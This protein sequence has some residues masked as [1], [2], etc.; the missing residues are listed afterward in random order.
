MDQH[1]PEPEAP[2]TL[3]RYSIE[4]PLGEGAGGTT[5]L[6]REVFAGPACLA[7]AS[8]DT[9]VIKVARVAAEAE[10][11][12]E[13]QALRRFK[14]R[15]IPKLLGWGRSAEGRTYMAL[16]ALPGPTLAA[17]MR[18][19]LTATETLARARSL[20]SAVAALHAAQIIHGD[21]KPENLICVGETEVALVDFGCVAR[22]EG[23]LGRGSPRY[24]APEILRGAPLSFATDRFSVGVIVEALIASAPEGDIGARTLECTRRALTSLTSVDP[25]QRAP[26]LSALLDALGDSQQ[27]ASDR[28]ETL[29]L[30]EPL[31]EREQQLEAIATS[32]DDWRSQGGQRG[33]WIR[34]VAGSGRSALL[35]E[36]LLLASAH[37]EVLKVPC[38]NFPDAA[39]LP[40]LEALRTRVANWS[41]PLVLGIDDWEL[42]SLSAR[43]R[44]FDRID[45]HP[46]PVFWLVVTA[47]GSSVDEPGWSSV[48]TPALTKAGALRLA[49]RL[50]SA[51]SASAWVDAAGALPGPLV[52]L[53][54]FLAAAA[55]SHKQGMLAVE[56][57]G[58]NASERAGAAR[59]LASPHRALPEND[60]FFGEVYRTASHRFQ[61][62][63]RVQGSRWVLA[64]RHALTPL[65]TAIGAEVL[66]EVHQTLLR[67]AHARK[68][69]DQARFHALEWVLAGNQALD[70]VGDPALWK[71][72]SLDQSQPPG[73]VAQVVA[74]RIAN[75]TEALPIE[76][77]AWCVPTLLLSPRQSGALWR[78]LARLRRR[79]G[80][81]ADVRLRCAEACLERGQPARALRYLEPLHGRALHLSDDSAARALA[82]R[83]RA[84]L[85]LGRYR[86]VLDEL[87]VLAQATA[88]LPVDL[89]ESQHRDLVEVEAAAAA[90]AG[91]VTR[92]RQA[93]Q[94]LESFLERASGYE[95][96]RLANTAGFVATK[97]SEFARA[98]RHF[99]H[100]LDLAFEWG[101]VPMVALSALNLGSVA[102]RVGAWAEAREAYAL[103]LG[104]ARNGR[105]ASTVATLHFNLARLYC[106][107]GMVDQAKDR[108]T[109]ARTFAAA[110][111]LAYFVAAAQSLLGEL[112]AQAG[113]FEHARAHF[114]AA[115]RA[116]RA[117]G[118]QADAFEMEVRLLMLRLDE[119]GAAGIEEALDRLAE[120]REASAKV[121]LI[122]EARARV[123]MAQ[124]RDPAALSAWQRVYD[125]AAAAQQIDRQAFAKS[126]LAELY[127]SQNAP[128]Q[129][130]AC[131]REALAAWERMS[132]PLESAMRAAFWRV[133]MRKEARRR[134]I[135]EA[136]ARPAVPRATGVRTLIRLYSRLAANS[137]PQRVLEEGLDA[138]LELSG[139]ERGMIILSGGPSGPQQVPIARRM[140]ATALEASE[141]AFSRSIVE[142]VLSEGVP[143]V[144]VDAQNDE[145]FQGQQSIHCLNL[146]AVMAVPIRDFEGV[147]GAFYLD[148]TLHGQAPE[149]DDLTLIQAFADQ[150]ALTLRNARLVK[151]L[152]QRA[153]DLETEKRHVEALL[154]AQAQQ[155]AELEA[156][157]QAARTQLAGRFTFAGLA[158]RCASMRPVLETL[159][160]VAKRDV[161]LLITGESGTGKE[162]I[163]RAAHHESHR[164]R[165]PFVPLNCAALPEHLIESELF[166]YVRG[167]FTGAQGARKGLF[168]EANGGTLF[169]DEI[170][171]LSL[172]VQ[173]KLLRA[174]QEQEVRPLGAD[175]AQRYDARLICATNRDLKIEVAEGRFREDLFFRLDVIALKL[176]P[177]RARLD[178][179]P[180]LVQTLLARV[181]EREKMPMVRL[182][183][184]AMRA[185]TRYAWPG[186]IRELE[187]VL[188]RAALMSEGGEIQPGALNLEPR[189]R[190][191]E[192]STSRQRVP[193]ARAAFRE[194]EARRI[195]Q[196]L[197]THAWNVS[198]VSRSLGI[199][200]ATLYRRLKRYGL[201]AE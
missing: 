17:R 2:P 103:G 45:T 24:L 81:S 178:D 106:D 135:S 122:D 121:A 69:W 41:G 35:D 5:F 165:G 15:A 57:S 188:T 48:A 78:V 126:Q 80:A 164:A 67:E 189:S 155:A 32:V 161:T 44:L 77:L 159:S 186:N 73:P 127:E 86:E 58:F 92:A 54:D 37:A 148:R 192:S 16:E 131:R 98:K 198:E 82:L 64:S 104:A 50:S 110:H 130:E 117:L 68:D 79:N 4:A 38:A 14:H 153:C 116:L 36:A 105:R 101:L 140:D 3:L 149:D 120:R 53:G 76:V 108:A 175:R 147:V 46:F 112:E 171:E 134:A 31:L 170:G 74:E 160:K 142:R 34:G 129:A 193:G 184:R 200:R 154:E 144:T 28:D 21:L 162:V 56:V 6:A 196:A 39:L 195:K 152:E 114:V 85:K 43:A 157:V 72:T 83:R 23:A 9:V 187:N 97:V 8:A 27:R 111:G 163:A 42:M 185:L 168:L 201:L 91:E 138:A 51:S 136:Q 181:A 100:A 197:E 139:A 102:Q 113:A 128:F 194:D 75:A 84:A 191:H 151:E 71:A 109:Y 183:G 179:L 107:L 182:S 93:L 95:R 94:V 65:R 40:M 141:A 13:M 177:L 60:P 150:V 18:A 30:R 63:F 146:K 90:G 166:G 88:A 158:S 89:A 7:H 70:V 174:L 29:R 10:L 143:V 47:P 55:P 167:A 52:A 49:T 1:K 145:R 173:S 190:P 118:A 169:L 66:G 180:D 12:R 33:V 96:L 137:D 199:P 11:L 124:R 20:T 125:R 25:T 61:R 176:P 132:A 123:A 26:D 22:G 115:E 62:L 172:S 19:P 119:V 87:G 156:E 133:P 59:L 99:E